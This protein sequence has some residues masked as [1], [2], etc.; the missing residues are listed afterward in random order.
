MEIVVIGTAFI[1][2]KG[3]PDGVYV[4]GSCNA[5]K[6]EYMHGGVARN[7]AE[8]AVRLGL[9]TTYLGLVD[10]SSA[11]S[12]VAEHL[13]AEGV[14]TEYVLARPDG[15]GAWMAVFDENGE[16]AASVSKR[17]DMRPLA[18][19]LDDR[20][21]EIFSTADSAIIEADLPRE[22]VEKTAALA[23]KYHVPLFA[24]ISDMAAAATQRDLL[25]RFNCL[26]CNRTEAGILFNND[27]TQLGKDELISSFSRE[28]RT[29]GIPAMVVTL[30]ADGAVYVSQ[31]GEGGY[32]PARPVKAVDATGAGDAFCAG[33]AAA[34]ACRRSLREA[35]ELGNYLASCVVT[36]FSNVCPRM[37]PRDLGLV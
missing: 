20:G 15:M 3:F 30:G 26:I 16:L 12:A 24:A 2:V 18:G 31:A 29:A 9:K 37:D 33:V 1:D 5:G 28:I 22:V 4:P 25:R 11:G 13:R 32:C 7:I 6:V 27:F 8:D 17:P 36:S 10:P 35:V 34:L 23:E 14:S 19:I 21:D